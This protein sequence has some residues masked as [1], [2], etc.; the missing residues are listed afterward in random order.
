MSFT[1][2]LKARVKDLISRDQERNWKQQPIQVKIS[3]DGARMRRNSSFILLSFSLLQAGDDVMSF[4]GNHTIAIVKVSERYSTLKESFGTAFTEINETI[5][6]GHITVDD[7]K[8]NV[9]FFLGGDY[10]FLPLM[11]GMKG[12]TSIYSCLWCKIAKDLRWKVDFDL[13]HYNTPSLLRTLEE[14]TKMSQKK[15]TQEKYSCEHEP[16]IKI[17]LNHVVIDELHLLRILDVLI[18]NLV[19]EEV[20]WDKTENFNRRKKDLQDSHI[21]KTSVYH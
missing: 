7:S 12:A 18:N 5:K 9:E 10:K 19:T 3:G 11:M 6:Q 4:N 14:M 2:L 1:G 15:G 20:E 16:L 17:E 13:D 21:K 8:F